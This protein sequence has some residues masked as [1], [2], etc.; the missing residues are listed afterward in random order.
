MDKL[1]DMVFDALDH[2]VANGYDKETREDKLENVAINLID[3]DFDIGE[4]RPEVMELIPHIEAWRDYAVPAS[5]AG[6]SELLG[7]RILHPY[8]KNK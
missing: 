5:V 1:R 6:K 4:L 8:P 3:Y 2:A 7:T